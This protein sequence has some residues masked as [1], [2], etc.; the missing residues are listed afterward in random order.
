[1][2]TKKVFIGY[3]HENGLNTWEVTDNEQLIKQLDPECKLATAFEILEWSAITSETFGGLIE[4]ADGLVKYEE[5]V[6]EVD[7]DGEPIDFKCE[8]RKVA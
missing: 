8:Y 4:C 3:Y 2:E 1:M 6:I 5:T 7:E